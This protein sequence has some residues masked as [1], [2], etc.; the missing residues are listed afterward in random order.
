MGRDST[1]GIKISSILTI[2]CSVCK[3]EFPLI[4]GIPPEGID[5]NYAFNCTDGKSYCREC[6]DAEQKRIETKRF[7]K[8]IKA[9]MKNVKKTYSC[10]L[11]VFHQCDFE[12]D[13]KEQMEQH[14]RENH[15]YG[16][17]QELEFVGRNEK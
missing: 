10:P 4:V 8:I 17:L 5:Y 7:E 15:R 1:G 11:R 16:G 13:T 6:F 14:I 9:A 2:N 12:C 3:G